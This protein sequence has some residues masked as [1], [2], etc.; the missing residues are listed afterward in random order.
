[1]RFQNTIRVVGAALL[2]AALP[3]WLRAEG[4]TA[5][6]EAQPEAK[7]ETKPGPKP[8]TPQSKAE[9]LFDEGRDALF[10]GKHDKAIELLTA[11]VT[12]DPA[13]TSYR[14]HLA[15]AYRFADKDKEATAQLEEIVKAAPDHVEAGQLLGEI[16]SRGK[17]WKEVVRVLEPLLTYRHDYP[18]YHMLAE[19]LY[20]LDQHDK[21][22]KNYE[23]AI[24]LNPNSAADHYQLGNIYLAANRFAK[25]ADAYQAALR[26]G[27]E[28]PV[29]RYKLASAMF[30]LRNYFGRVVVRTVRSGTADTISDGWYLIEPVPG[31]KDTWYCAPEQSAAY[32]VAK[33][34]A[35]GLEDRPDIQVLRA[36]I[37]LNARRF[38]RAYEMFAKIRDTV[39]KDDQAL[40]YFYFAEA[41]FGTDRYDEYLE[42]LGKA[43]ELKPSDY[44]STRV[45]AFIRVADQYNQAGQLDKYI[46]YL[47]DAVAESP[48]T[49]ALHLKLG[50]AY[51]EALRH[52]DAITQWQMVLDLEPDHPE[53]TSLLNMI[54]KAR[55][56]ALT[57]V[58]PTTPGEG[59][60]PKPPAPKP[61]PNEPEPAP[62]TGEKP[63]EAAPRP[64]EKPKASEKPP[65][66]EKPKPDTA[67]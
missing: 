8:E 23:E 29:L 49:A 62:K 63:V 10:Q 27:M 15:R 47:A 6:P 53:R 41:A 38:Q 45:D 19:A 34:L 67:K 14:L 52:N 60:K 1:M 57:A 20:N 61:V 2:I 12:A 21:A 11:A 65:S 42:F 9:K 36:S 22:R 55:N 33:A 50:N 32:Q 26:L 66:E 3:V 28:G 5:K 16:Y 43:I 40:F 4:P 31:R 44:A 17:Q 30:N 7:P 51:E 24:K 58:G 37:Y 39:P 35:D 54:E 18:T 25:A 46:R 56:A 59:P 64:E 48:R 13:K